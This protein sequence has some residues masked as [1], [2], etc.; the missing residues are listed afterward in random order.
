L[1]DF[2]KSCNASMVSSMGVFCKGK[3]EINVCLHI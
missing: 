3:N 2:T 1:P